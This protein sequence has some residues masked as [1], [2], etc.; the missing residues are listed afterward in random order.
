MLMQ[1]KW[2]IPNVFRD[3]FYEKHRRYCVWW[4]E[5]RRDEMSRMLEETASGKFL[6]VDPSGYAA[7][8]ED[9]LFEADFHH[10]MREMLIS[11]DSCT[12]FP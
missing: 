9:L 11:Q 6:G 3:W 8:P 12:E 5:N 2:M 7:S 4:H 10:R 1:A